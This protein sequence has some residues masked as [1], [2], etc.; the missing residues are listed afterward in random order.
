MLIRYLRG[1]GFFIF[2]VVVLSG[3]AFYTYRSSEQQDSK[4]KQSLKIFGA[5]SLSEVSE[6]EVQ[7]FSAGGLDPS[8]KEASSEEPGF[9]ARGLAPF[10]LVRGEGGGEWSIRQGGGWEDLADSRTVRDW[11]SSVLAEEA[12]VLEDK[13][14]LSWGDYG[15]DKDYST[16]SLRGGSE[17]QRVSVRISRE[18]AFDGKFF[19]RRGDTLLLGEVIWGQLKSRGIKFFRSRRVVPRG[20]SPLELSFHSGEV[21]WSF[22]D[23]EG[24]WQW[25]EGIKNPPFPL[26]SLSLREWWQELVSLRLQ[27]EGDIPPDTPQMRK[28]HKLLSPGL[29]IQAR[30]P[31]G[32]QWSLNLSP[33]NGGMFYALVSK[34][35]HLLPLTENEA[36]KLFLNADRLRD[37]GQP[38]RFQQSEV[39]EVKFHS[40]DLNLKLKKEEE[41]EK[42]V[43]KSPQ[44]G[45]GELN[46]RWVGQVLNHLGN[47][48]AQTYVGQKPITPGTEITLRDSQ[49]KVLLH[50]Q[51]E[52]VA[53]TGGDDKTL[54]V[55][56]H[57]GQEVMTLATGDFQ[58]LMSFQPFQKDSPEE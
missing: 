43:L 9:T 45:Q 29:S 25:S 42:W 12:P 53:G 5:L 46:P 17:G 37:H 56:S 55:K 44:A 40:G 21:Q 41:G 31:G 14:P 48:K 57:K 10:R 24:E 15:L 47:L 2:C 49:N 50:L 27:M 32:R 19:L 38:F 35:K 52:S 58:T 33:E 6:V 30:F 8:G 23:R 54:F 3:F 28:K 36:Q 26:S 51:M 34:R 39:S 1:H 7:P 16:L 20:E 22:I 11:L 13:E 18:S 4:K